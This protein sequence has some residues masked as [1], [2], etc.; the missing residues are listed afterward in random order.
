MSKTGLVL[1]GGGLRGVFTGGV[2]DCFLDKNI[3]FDYVVGVSAGSCNLFAYVGKRRGYARACMIQKDRSNSFWGVPQM[4]E[5]HKFVDLDKIFYEYT[6]QYDFDF[7]TFINNPQ[8]WEMVVSNILTGQAEYM[9]TDDIETSRLIGKA[10]CS[11]PGLTE[12]VAIGDQLYMDGGICDSIPVQRALD[13]GCDKLVVI[14]TRKKGNYSHINEATLALFRRIYGKYPNF[15]KALENRTKLYRD[16]VG[17]AEELERQG[18]AIIIRP[19]IKEVSRLESNEDELL[20]SYYHG[21]TKAK[22]YID[23][24]SQL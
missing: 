2:I 19:S 15:L 22:E 13:R 6:E 20:M 4:I 16:Q 10:S 11:M 18:K 1:E 9:H 7:D 24:I 8:D 21:Y 3:K 5:S 23:R 12:P 17:L 14:L